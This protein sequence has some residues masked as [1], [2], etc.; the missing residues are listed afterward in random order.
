[1]NGKTLLGGMT[2]AVLLVGCGGTDVPTPAT[3]GQAAKTNAA[4]AGPSV[5]LT[6]DTIRVEMITDAAGSHFVPA[7]VTARRGDVVRFTLTMGVHNVHFLADSNVGVSGLPP[8]SDMLQLP[9]QTY[10]MVVAMPSG[11]SY[12]YQC[13]P[14]AML[15]MVGYITVE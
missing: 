11:G 12:F 15:G 14:H 3:G 2:A 8:M 6:G 1:M 5:P 10:D 13:D 9:G 7:D 4:A